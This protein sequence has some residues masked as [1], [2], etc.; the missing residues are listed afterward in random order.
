MFVSGYPIADDNEQN[1]AENYVPVKSMTQFLKTML[2]K[3]FKD[4]K[5]TAR[6]FFNATEQKV[7]ATLENISNTISES[8]E[9]IQKSLVAETAQNRKYAIQNDEKVKSLNEFVNTLQSDLNQLMVDHSS[10]ESLVHQHTQLLEKAKTSII[11]I[12]EGSNSNKRQLQTVVEAMKQVNRRID[13][14][15][16]YNALGV[17]Q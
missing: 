11:E 12:N 9:S 14:Y 17:K 4:E 8:V 5:V 16:E 6:K 10:T 7:N 1:L 2:R 15:G 13:S 3:A